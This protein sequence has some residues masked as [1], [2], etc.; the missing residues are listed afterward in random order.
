MGTFSNSTTRPPLSPVAKYDPSESNSTAEITSAKTERRIRK[1][2][3]GHRWQEGLGQREPCHG[4]GPPVGPGPRLLERL[5]V[6]YGFHYN[7]VCAELL[8]GGPRSTPTRAWRHTAADSPSCTSS[9]GVRSPKHCRNCHSKGSPPDRHPGPAGPLSAGM[10]PL[11]LPLH[12]GTLPR[13]PLSIAITYLRST[14]QTRA[15]GGPGRAP[16][17]VNS[18]KLLGCVPYGRALGVKVRALD[19]LCKGFA[20]WLRECTFQ[21]CSRRSTVPL[22]SPVTPL[23]LFLS[24]PSRHPDDL[25]CL[26]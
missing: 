2:G 20:R 4:G 7:L 12:H 11:L 14:G 24:Q 26:T 8:P 13:A 16:T 25:E 21:S 5:I 1:A 23:C 6:I 10:L 22:F 19:A 9:P 3:G 18:A 15:I 17:A